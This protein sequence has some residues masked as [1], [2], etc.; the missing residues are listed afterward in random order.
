MF[1]SH[2]NFQTHINEIIKSC[3]FHLWNI[4]KI[5]SVLSLSDLE[6]ITRAFVF[7]RLDYC[8]ALYLTLTQTVGFAN[9][10]VPSLVPVKFR[11]DRTLL[12][13][14][15][16]LSPSSSCSW[17]ML[18]STRPTSWA[19]T[20]WFTVCRPF[21]R[22]TGTAAM[23]LRIRRSRYGTREGTEKNNENNISCLLTPPSLLFTGNM[24]GLSVPNQP[25]LPQQLHPRRKTL[26]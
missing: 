6:K 11:I 9:S 21:S 1:D 5:E 2:L 25:N 26:N 20:A 10:C 13:S 12:D 8:H 17:T 16:P 19:V 14:L 23:K 22:S 7:S 15:L 4:S 3:Y 24:H 18:R